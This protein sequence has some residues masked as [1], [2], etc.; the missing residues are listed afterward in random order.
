MSLSTHAAA[1]KA[2]RTELKKNGI[3]ARVTCKSYSGGSSVSVNVADQAPWIMEE[4][5]TFCNKFQM[6]H[7]NGMEDIYEYSNCS[8]LPQVKFVFVQNNYSEAVEKEA[9]TYIESRLEVAK[10]SQ[11]DLQ[12]ETFSYLCGDSQL[13]CYFKKPVIKLS[14]V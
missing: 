8:D 13:G 4:I 5:K 7:F 2:I 14:R 1:A 9:R 11:Y 3:A 6:G 10:F 12:R